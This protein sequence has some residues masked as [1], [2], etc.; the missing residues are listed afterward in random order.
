[1]IT[2][3]IDQNNRGG[4]GYCM[5][6]LR[7]AMDASVPGVST[8]DRLDDADVVHLND[9]NPWAGVVHGKERRRDHV[10]SLARGLTDRETPLVVTE[11]GS[12]HFSEARGYAYGARLNVGDI[13]SAVVRATER[14][15]ATQVA[16]V[17]A[18]SGSVRR[19]LVAGGVDPGKVHVAYHG[20]NRRYRDVATTD[21]DPFVLH[22]STYSPR[23]NPA[24]VVEVA[25]R[26]DV[27]VVIAG[28]GWQENEPGLS[29]VPGIDV[30]GY[31][32][33]GD[34]VDLY[35]RAAAFYFPT[36][37]EGFGLP[38][39]E[40][41]AC[42]TA[43]VTSD[44]YAVPE[45][46]GDAAVTC[47]PRDVDRHVAELEHLLADDEARE[48]L[49]RAAAARGRSFTWERTARTVADVYERVVDCD[50]QGV[51]TS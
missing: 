21:P 12:I 17:F 39:L 2:A 16:A 4:A 48:R 43:V 49:E 26:L 18:I 50:G 41:M 32:P 51:T 42:G 30:R 13:V 45:V 5:E 31:V 28:S 8:T 11:H 3:Y 35:N 47:D 44:V 29:A 14:L 33:E 24:A 40:A 22:V 46:A 38:V 1:M 9:L 20:V 36:L 25:R 15:Y 19:H 23:K 37:H 6:Q 7:D 10:R 34:L 27:P